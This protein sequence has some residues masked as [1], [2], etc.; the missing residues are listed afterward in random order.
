MGLRHPD[1]RLSLMAETIGAVMYRL[2]AAQQMN[3]AG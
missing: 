1:F 3:E 2:K